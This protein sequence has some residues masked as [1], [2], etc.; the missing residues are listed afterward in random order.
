[1][2]FLIIILAVILADSFEVLAASFASLS[3]G[4][5]PFFFLILT[6]LIHPFHLDLLVEDEPS[7][8]T[9]DLSVAV[10]DSFSEDSASSSVEATFLE[11]FS[12]FLE[13]DNTTRQRKSW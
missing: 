8:F 10:G 5:A 6:D 2:A 12:F 7:S 1:M 13:H 11:L 9:P 3:D 4:D